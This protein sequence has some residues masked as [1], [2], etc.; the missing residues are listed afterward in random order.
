MRISDWSS[1]VCSSD[2]VDIAARR[3]VALQAHGDACDVEVAAPPVA[4]DRARHDMPERD[5]VDPDRLLPACEAVAGCKI[6]ER[7]AVARQVQCLAA[8]HYPVEL[9]R[10]VGRVLPLLPLVTIVER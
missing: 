1:D 4:C 3:S 2:L 6:F 9:G 5:G 7:V 8:F 10:I